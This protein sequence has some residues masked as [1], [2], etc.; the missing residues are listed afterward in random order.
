MEPEVALRQGPALESAQQVA[1][2]NTGGAV[3]EVDPANHG[4]A[5]L[6]HERQMHGARVALHLEV[7]LR[8][9]PVYERAARTDRKRLHDRAAVQL[10]AAGGCAAARGNG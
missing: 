2:R 6:D 5:L 7:D 1:L 8:A 9:A 3:A 10:H 4:V